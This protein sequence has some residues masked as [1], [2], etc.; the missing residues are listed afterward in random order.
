MKEAMGDKQHLLH[1]LA[2]IA[3]VENYTKGAGLTA[4]LSDSMMRFASVK[5]I[6]IIGEAANYVSEPLKNKFPDIQW[7]QITGMRHI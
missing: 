6:E 5:Q 7:G 4:F 3:E 2:A 1:I